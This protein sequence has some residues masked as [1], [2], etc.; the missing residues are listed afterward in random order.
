MKSVLEKKRELDKLVKELEDTRE[1]ITEYKDKIRR[2][3]EKSNVKET[4]LKNYI[5]SL[6]SKMYN[7]DVTYD[8]KI[9]DMHGNKD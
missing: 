2:L 4:E 3:F 8:S 1:Q 6:N 7:Y 5:A 9:D